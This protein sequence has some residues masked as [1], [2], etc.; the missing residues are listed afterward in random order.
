MSD[1]D[2]CCP[3]DFAVLCNRVDIRDALTLEAAKHELVVQRLPEPVPTGNFDIAHLTAIHHHS[4]ENVYAWA[5]EVR[6]LE[7]T[8]G[9][10]PF[11]PGRCEAPK[12]A[13]MRLGIQ[14]IRGVLP[15]VSRELA[16]AMPQLFLCAFCSLD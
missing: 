8:E 13:G 2:H 4:F 1:R 16:T 3:P 7:I 5:G 14:S 10:S 15:Y 6:T 11:R 12:I 9:G